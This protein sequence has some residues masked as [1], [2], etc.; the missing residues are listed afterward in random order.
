MAS[1]GSVT[2]MGGGCKRTS[3]SNLPLAK[4]AVFPISIGFP[5]SLFLKRFLCQA[6]FSRIAHCWLHRVVTIEIELGFLRRAKKI[7]FCIMETRGVSINEI[8]FDVLVMILIQ[9][10][11]LFCK[12]ELCDYHEEANKKSSC[13]MNNQ[14]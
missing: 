10:K 2:I 14:S 12:I 7:K 6:V 13:L 3:T 1:G 11:R 5:Q 8:Y 4:I 9:L